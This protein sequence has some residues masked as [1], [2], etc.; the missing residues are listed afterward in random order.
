MNKLEIIKLIDEKLMKNNL[1]FI[2]LLG[3]THKIDSYQSYIYE[4]SLIKKSY[5]KIAEFEKIAMDYLN[6]M[7]RLISYCLSQE[8]SI[9]KS[10]ISGNSFY[11][12]IIK[13]SY[14]YSQSLKLIFPTS[15]TLNTESSL[16]TIIQ[17]YSELG[18]DN[19]INYIDL[20]RNPSNFNSYLSSST[21]QIVAMHYLLF[22]TDHHS[23]KKLSRNLSSSTL[24]QET[25]NDIKDALTEITKEKN[26]FINYM[27]KEKEKFSIWFSNCNNDYNTFIG[28]SHSDFNQLIDDSKESLYSL[29]NTYEEK[30]KIEKPSEYLKNK[31]DEY[32][33]Q[34]KKWMLLDVLVSVILIFLLGIIIDPEINI[35]NTLIS[36]TLF[37]GNLPVYNSIILLA[38]I[39]LIVYVLRIMIKITLSTKHLSEEYRQKHILSYFYL[40]LINSGKIDDTVGQTILTLLFAKADTGLIKN[41]NSNEYESI[42][43]S[44]TSS[45]K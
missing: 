26:D 25:K 10:T 14:N 12:H 5:N 37:S 38:I 20:L 4:F 41:D 39:C 32:S 11:S 40:S 45:G 22:K 36:V 28:S 17:V 29:L 35:N 27:N 44:L 7:D 9:I 2:D 16:P 30:L 19:L 6:R 8:E 33:E 1:E 23:T 13:A 24:Y 21:K 18:Y 43:K 31:A 15:L 34:T 3:F 42:L